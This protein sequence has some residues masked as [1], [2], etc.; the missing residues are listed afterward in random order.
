MTTLSAA[1]PT[2]AISDNVLVMP[3]R[4]EGERRATARPA[5]NPRRR[6]SLQQGRALETLGHAVEYLVDSRMF[7]VQAQNFKAEQDAL[8]LLKRMSRIVFSEC[9]EVVSVWKRVGKLCRAS[10]ERKRPAR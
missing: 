10:F 8:E 1:S 4:P 6:G 3:P 5:P 2:P 9:P 7:L